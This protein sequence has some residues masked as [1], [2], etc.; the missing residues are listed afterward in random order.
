MGDLSAVINNAIIGRANLRDKPNK[1][2]VV[3]WTKDKNI[4]ELDGVDTPCYRLDSPIPLAEIDVLHL[5]EKKNSIRLYSFEL[6]SNNGYMR[7][8]FRRQLLKQS[9]L[10][11]LSALDGFYV[12]SN[13]IC[14]T[15]T[16]KLREKPFEIKVMY[17][18]GHEEGELKEKPLNILLE[19]LYRDSMIFSDMS[20]YKIDDEFYIRYAFVL[21]QD[22]INEDFAVLSHYVSFYKNLILNN[23]KSIT[24]DILNSKGKKDLLSIL[25]KYEKINRSYFKAFSRF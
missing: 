2:K 21:D 15:L 23:Y 14:M 6:K 13:N 20:I 5:R 8:S 4:R 25:V 16:N 12:Y 11:L 7:N 3:V 22:I 9:L 1:T 17:V 19:T 10:L 24:A 18:G